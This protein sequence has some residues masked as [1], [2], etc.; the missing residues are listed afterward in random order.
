MKIHFRNLNVILFFVIVLNLFSTITNAQECTSQSA[1][2]PQMGAMINVPQFVNLWKIS[3]A[4]DKHG[5]LYGNGQGALIIGDD[6][7]PIE[8]NPRGAGKQRHAIRFSMGVILPALRPNDILKVRYRGPSSAITVAG[9]NMQAATWQNIQ[10]NTPSAGYTTAELRLGNFSSI[11]NGFQFGFEGRITE[12]QIVRPGYDFDDYRLLVDE[13]VTHTKHWKSIRFMGLNGVNGNEAQT[14]GKRLSKNSPI[15]VNNYEWGLTKNGRYDED[16]V[17][18][19]IES[20]WCR[21]TSWEDQIDI[22]NYLN[23]DMWINVPVMADD[24]YIKNLA[25]LIKSRL[26]PTLNVNVEIGN[27]IWNSGAPFMCFHMHM[28]MMADEFAGTI[29]YGSQA[30]KSKIRGGNFCPGCEIP[31]DPGNVASRIGFGAFE[32]M[33]RWQARRLKEYADQFATVF[34]W[35]ADG[36]DVGNRIR[37]ILA[38]M[39]AYAANGM[40]WN[41][42]PGID[43]LR[44]AYG[45]DAVNKYLYAVAITNYT[46]PHGTPISASVNEIVNSESINIDET[47]AEY[48]TETHPYGT[49]G[50]KMDGILGK[51]RMFG[52]KMY[53]YEGGNE[54]SGANWARYTNT[55]DYFRDPRSGQNTTKNLTNWF[56]WFGYDALFI[57]NGDYQDEPVS[58]YGMSTTLNE[59][60][61]IRK[62]YLDF[63]NSPAPPL[64]T[65][66]GNVIGAQAI[67]TLD[68]RKVAGYWSN[69]QTGL[70]GNPTVGYSTFA[71]NDYSFKSNDNFDRPFIIRCQKNGKY[72]VSLERVIVKGIKAEDDR[73]PTYCDI[74]INEKLVLPGVNVSVE[75]GSTRTVNGGRVMYWTKEFEIDIPYGVHSFRVQPSLPTSA[76]KGNDFAYGNPFKNTL[77]LMSY[78]FTLSTALP[79]FQPKPVIGD[80]VVCRGN[81]KASYEVGENDPSSCEYEWKGF[82]AGAKLLPKELVPSTSPA[83]YSSGQGTYKIFIDWGNVAAGTYNL[84]V[85]AKNL[86]ASGGWQ[87]SP[88]RNFTV[89]VEK[90]GFDISP[91]PVCQNQPTTFTPEPMAATQFLWD[92]GKFGEP[93]A[94]RFT[95]ATSA[96]PLN[97]TYTKAGVYFV[98]L[99]ASDASGKESIYNNT[100]NVISCNSPTVIT[101]LSYCKGATAV[102]VTATPTNGGTN[103]KWYTQAIGGTALPSAPTPSTANVD[104]ISYWVSQQNLLGES[105]RAKLDIFIIDVPTAPLVSTPN[106]FVYCIGATANLSDLTS[107][108]STPSGSTLKWYL[109]SST[110]STTTPTAPNT[111]SATSQVWNVSASVGICESPKSTLTVNVVP[112]PTFTVSK[113]EPAS[114]GIN[115]K[116]IL[117]GLT[118]G[119]K[120]KV[121]YSR[122]TTAIPPADSTANASGQIVLNLSQGTY[123]KI[124]LDNGSCSTENPESFTL[125]EPS[126]PNFTVA[127]VNPLICG[128][129][130]A[131]ELR[132]LTANLTYQV[133]IGTS[134]AEARTAN[135]QGVIVLSLAKGSYQNIVVSQGLCKTTNSVLHQLIEPEAVTP[136]AQLRE[137]NYCQNQNINIA[138]ITNRVS[139]SSGYTLRWY[140][141][142]N[143][144]PSTTPSLINSS[145]PGTYQ[146]YVSQANENGCESIKLLMNIVVGESKPLTLSAISP[147][148]CGSSDGTITIGGLG[149]L[150]EYNIDSKREGIVQPVKKSISNSDGEIIIDNL[151]KGVY[152]DVTV[153]LVIGSGCFTNSSQSLTLTDPGAPTVLPV[154]SGGASYCS[155]ATIAPLR[156]EA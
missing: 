69:W 56:G 67:T 83:R 109:G 146:R 99:K 62:A 59:M 45:P 19:G 9:L 101:P 117:S 21:G 35:K 88:V 10:A 127:V 34:G 24:D 138:D 122:G 53:C 147:S 119:T 145:S 118:A 125:T 98:S 105:D 100:I 110:T 47:Y 131:I 41:I 121:S 50:N 104:T 54:I 20:G 92:N 16:N 71:N 49:M 93:N 153:T 90:C 13:Y 74:Y 112:G 1:P 149:K 154:V 96:T 140:D 89:K 116:I 156:A 6:G 80:I 120:Y 124:K 33:Q 39:V 12:I 30:E 91:N 97:V 70:F 102:P 148:Q 22:C 152:S 78:K 63:A 23:I 137:F 151:G 65:V 139:V 68:A 113:E 32:T 108:V 136:V 66:R 142:E 46:T 51:A 130:G 94:N 55:T 126:S 58:A 64:S 103:L 107:K 115:G 3:S 4:K 134:A 14:W 133:S 73:F 77:E 40:A 11:T 7:W 79:P 84:S 15:V 61:H 106:P 76:R 43:F 48:S 5:Q 37:L 143:G 82:P 18:E 135:A 111:S 86:N 72:K 25:L 129:L 81:N 60:T 42:G 114:C 28:Q 95:V 8:N 132:G 26:K 44:K 141:E 123:S 29:G 52:L 144:S 128:A 85:E 87:S 75:G 38:G 27:E 2:S 31:F 155:G 17:P 57:K 36:G 150:L